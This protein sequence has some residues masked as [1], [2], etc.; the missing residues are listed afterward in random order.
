MYCRNCGTKN[1]ESDHYCRNCGND[2]S[3][4]E[5]VNNNKEVSRKGGNTLALIAMICFF[6][7]PVLSYQG[8]KFIVQK[9]MDLEFILILLEWTMIISPMLSLVLIV[10]ARIKYPQNGFSKLVL[11]LMILTI[12]GF[13]IFLAMLIKSC[14]DGCASIGG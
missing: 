13:I 11:I 5:L 2:L 12:I 14:M 9:N 4:N 7:L 3:K 10:I 1:L 8:I 6:F